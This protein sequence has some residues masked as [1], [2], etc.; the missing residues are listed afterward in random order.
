MAQISVGY[1][2]ETVEA[3]L[4][5]SRFRTE[6]HVPAATTP[7]AFAAACDSVGEVHLASS[8]R[9]YIVD[10]VTAT[11]THPS[12]TLGAS[13]RASVHLAA[14]ARAAAAVDGRDFATPDDVAALALAILSHRVIAAAGADTTEILR[15]IA[16]STRVRTG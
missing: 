6:V 16:T 15:E 14:A 1:P 3:E 12:L 7:A 13:P 9:T 2:S 4:L 11:R 10:L 5:D 8:V